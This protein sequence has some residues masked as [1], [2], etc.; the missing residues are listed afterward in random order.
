MIQWELIPMIKGVFFVMNPSNPR[1][2][3]QK[4][5]YLSLLTSACVVGR[6]FFVWLPNVQPMTAILLLLAFYGSLTDTLLVSLLSLFITNLYLGLG[7]WTIS[8]MIAFSGIILFF[9]CIRKL[10]LVAKHVSIQ[11]VFSFFCGIIYG[12][13]VSRIETFIYQVPSFWVY[14]F[15][16]LPFDFA[17][18][19]G[20]FFF[21]I[22]LFPLF[23]RIIFPLYRKHC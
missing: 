14:Y 23:Q 5:A 19:M 22:L 17:H 13:I 8:Q 6:L 18:G 11:A 16:G 10:P 4:F 9:H 12:L 2:S 15:Q 7:T 20:N 3:I 21:Y 1:F